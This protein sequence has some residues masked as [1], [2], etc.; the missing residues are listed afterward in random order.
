VFSEALSP[1]HN[2]IARGRLNQLDQHSIGIRETNDFVAEPLGRA[3][4]AN[5]VF[6]QSFKPISGRPRR[7]GKG[8]GADFTGT[9]STATSAGPWEERKDRSRCTGSIAEIKVVTAWI[10]EID[11][12]FDEPESE[13]FD[14]E[15]EIALR[16]TGNRGNMV[17]TGYIHLVY[18]LPLQL[19]ATLASAEAEA[20]RAV[21]A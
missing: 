7:N 18:V 6:F 13:Q 14:I 1:W 15:V 17:K 2:L 10:I 5:V 4:S 8:G 20:M 11:G 9:T 19:C 16:I 3:F 12:A 21:F